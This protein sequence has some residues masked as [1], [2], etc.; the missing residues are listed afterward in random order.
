V[1]I[2]FDR[3]D[4]IGSSEADAPQPIGRIGYFEVLN[5][6]KVP[7]EGV[8]LSQKGYYECPFCR[9][10]AIKQIIDWR[11]EKCSSKLIKWRCFTEETEQEHEHYDHYIKSFYERVDHWKNK[12]K[13]KKEKNG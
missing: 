4:K 1:P 7:F 9:E 2:N 5:V 10:Y 11:C 13:K 8:S 3:A 12:A 6:N